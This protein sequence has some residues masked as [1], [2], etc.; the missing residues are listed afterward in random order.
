MNIPTELK[1]PPKRK[2]PKRLDDGAG[3]QVHLSGQD[4]MKVKF[5]YATLDRLIT[6]LD[7]RFP[8][9]LCDFAYMQPDNVECAD[10]EKC[11]HRLAERYEFVN[12]DR[13]VA[14]WRLSL[15][16][17]AKCARGATLSLS[18][19]YPKK[20]S[21]FHDLRMLYRIA[22]SLPVTTASVE[23]GF[24][25]L[26]LLETKLRSTMTEERLEALMLAVVERDLLL[27]LSTDDLV[28]QFAAGADR[29]M[30]LG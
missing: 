17:L 11:V 28:A 8:K 4:A 6:E 30:N 3:Q 7:T 24:S 14:Q 5:Y 20:C 19:A 2:V 15:P 1:E 9:E 10:G 18:E 16:A 29:R 25:K 22:L 23:R 13:A 26:A 21:D 27:Q 12:T